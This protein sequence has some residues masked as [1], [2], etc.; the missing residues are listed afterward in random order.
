MPARNSEDY[1]EAA[2]RSAL[3]QSFGDFELIVSDNASTD[4]TVEIVRD[5]M[6]RDGRVHLVHHTGGGEVGRNRN[7]GLGHAI[8][9]WATFLDADDLWTP[10]HLEVHAAAL[11]RHPNTAMC[12]SD[13]RR[14]ADT[15]DSALPAVLE[16]NGFFEAGASH[17]NF[18]E[19]LASGVSLVQLDA[20]RMLK[21]ACLTYCPMNTASVTLRRATMIHHKIGFHDNWTINED[22]D[23]WLRMLGRGDV[24]GIRRVLA[25]YRIN[26]T[27]LTSD[28]IRYFEG[29]ARAHLDWM[30]RTWPNLTTDERQIY[31]QKVAGFLTSAAN[32]HSNRGDWRAALSCRLQAVRVQPSIG[33]IVGLGKSIVRQA[34]T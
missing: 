4:S 25:Y 17:V 19:Q 20:E 6:Q 18:Q 33:Q 13:F 12:F 30:E 10:D 34:L 16:G 3:D 27:S 26:P 23:C 28:N 5:F 7:F 32:E 2:I 9:K 22:L 15:L 14:F 8:G 24:I 11:A 29:M 21:L 31:Q 1:I